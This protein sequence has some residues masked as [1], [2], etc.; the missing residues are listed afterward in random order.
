MNRLMASIRDFFFSSGRPQELGYCRVVFYLWLFLFY[1][2]LMDTYGSQNVS[3]FADVGDVFRQPIFP[4]GLLGEWVVPHPWIDL[5]VAMWKVSL[6]LSC[7]GLFTRTSMWGAFLLGSYVIGLPF[8]YG[9][10]T[11]TG[12]T[13]V[14]GLGIMALSR[15]GDA[16]SVDAWWRGRAG[17]PAAQPGGEYRWPIRFIWV[18]LATIYFCSGISKW[19][20]NGAGYLN[21]DVMAGFFRQRSFAWYTQP[22]TDWGY[23]LAEVRWFCTAASAWTLFGETFFWLSLVSR[24]ARMVL[25]PAMFLTHIGVA[26]LL[27]PQFF[28][29]LSLYV[30]WIPWSLSAGSY[31]ATTSFNSTAPPVTR[32]ASR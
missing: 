30:F 21:P 23:R 22:L 17:R 13:L 12:G 32:H 4:F 11:H 6:L 14:I 26:A 7:V 16:I 29:F 8:N 25:V 1:L 10:M 28:Q 15:A 18:L 20:N 2:P 19:I 24:R 9:T 3:A 5:L 31:G 27:G